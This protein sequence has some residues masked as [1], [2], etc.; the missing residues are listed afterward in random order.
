M[1]KTYDLEII[2][3]AKKILV[4]DNSDPNVSNNEFCIHTFIADRVYLSDIPLSSIEIP[5]ITLSFDSGSGD[6]DLPVE[7]GELRTKIW[8]EQAS[9]QARVK[10]RRCTARVSALLN[11]NPEVFNANNSVI[12]VRLCDK[13]SHNILV[14][15][16]TKMYYGSLVFDVTFKRVIGE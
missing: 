16:D 8:Y 3:A 15:P 4:D 11:Q 9:Y 12:T 1:S 13:T 7:H 2:K 5:Q 6:D 10:C 14:D